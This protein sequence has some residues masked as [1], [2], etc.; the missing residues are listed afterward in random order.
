MLTPPHLSHPQV[1]TYLVEQMMKQ[2][3]R[4]TVDDQRMIAM[5]Y[6]LD[7]KFLLSVYCLPDTVPGILSLAYLIC[8]VQL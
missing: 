4:L 2:L 7:S 3:S 1:R 8:T 5:F 6:L